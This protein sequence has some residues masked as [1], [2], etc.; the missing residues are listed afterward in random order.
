MKLKKIK[1]SRFHQL[2]NLQILK[3][4][5]KKKKKFF[6]IKT[7]IKSTE[8]I[9]NKIANIIFTFHLNNCRILFLG[10][11]NNF[12]KILKNSNHMAIPSF[13]WFNGMLSNNA[14]FENNNEKKAKIPRNIYKLISRLKKKPNL[15][16]I[17][18]LHS[19]STAIKESSVLQIPAISINNN[20]NILNTK[21]I[22]NSK[23]NYSFITE[24][25][26][27]TNFFFSF[28][29]TVINH[30]KKMKKVKLH[31]ERVKQILFKK[32]NFFRF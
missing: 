27:N 2:L 24:K 29:K 15:I 19:S 9:L 5:S 13:V 10:F 30:A 20:F 11:P 4:H 3:L 22:Y 25:I 7:D 12:S 8:V 14:S 31:N 28:I 26:E 18:N 16:M 6:N 21:S 17:Y 1:K 23:E 32:D